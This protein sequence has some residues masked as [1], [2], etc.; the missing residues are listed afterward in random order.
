MEVRFTYEVDRDVENFIK[1]MK[2]VNSSGLARFHQAFV[3]QYGAVQDE[4]L[5][6]AYIL[7]F[8]A[9]TGVDTAAKV[10]EISNRWASVAAAF[11]ERAERIFGLKY[12]VDSVTA[13]LTTNDR[14]TYNIAEN[15]FFVNL[16]NDRTN[17]VVMH[18]LF[19]FYTWHALAPLRKDILDFVAYNDI[20]ESLT[21]L[22]NIEFT[23]LL[24]GTKD[25]GYPQHQE[26][27]AKI[28]EAWLGSRDLQQTVQAVIP[29][30][31]LTNK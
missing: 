31:H 20:K 28:H 19:H 29:V 6:K 16:K 2:T 7:N 23:D 10:V 17:H 15:Y 18:E 24:G 8:L 1:S 9:Q 4:A 3:E 5:V 11:V 13:Y 12:P 21:E 30:E 25:N 26:L 22:L 27:R 14:C